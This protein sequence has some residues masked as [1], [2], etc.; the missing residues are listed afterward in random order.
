[1]YSV[2]SNSVIANVRLYA[3]FACGVHIA[4]VAVTS[5]WTVDSETILQE[6]FDS[7]G[8]LNETI[9]QENFD[10]LGRLNETILQKNFDS[11]GGLN[12]TI[13]QENFDSPGRLNETILQ[14]NFDSLG[15]LNETILEK[16]FDSPSRLNE[17][18]LEKNFDS[19]GRLSER[20][21][22]ELCTC[23]PLLTFHLTGITKIKCDV[24]NVTSHVQFLSD[25]TKLRDVTEL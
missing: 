14:E 3:L 7:P 21:L 4:A 17:T 25:R 1:M 16:N 5:E 22:C 6:N 20:E 13:L 18:I 15:R 10:S 12:E 2:T 11:L 9:L 23:Q 8:R 24:V 19:P